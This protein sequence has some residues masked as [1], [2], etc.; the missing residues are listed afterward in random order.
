MPY[1]TTEAEVWVDLEDFEDE[2]LIT[3]MNRRGLSGTGA[4]GTVGQVI[5][6]MYEYEKMGKDIQPLMRELYQTALNRIA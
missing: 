5:N 6:A 4:H 3:E 1:V 2:E